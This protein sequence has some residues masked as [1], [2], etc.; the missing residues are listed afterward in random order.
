LKKK[1]HD[2]DQ[3]FLTKSGELVSGDLSFRFNTLI[4]QWIKNVPEY[5]EANRS[6]ISTNTSLGD[7]LLEKF[8]A[9]IKLDEF[10]EATETDMEQV[11][12]IFAWR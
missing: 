10:K 4:D 12:G 1:E 7:Y 2:G 11:R 8:E 6:Q 5:V 9:E 3:L